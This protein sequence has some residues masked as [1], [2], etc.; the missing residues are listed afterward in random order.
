[1]ILGQISSASSNGKHSAEK[2]YKE[3]DGH[4]GGN[5]IWKKAFAFAV[6]KAALIA[7]WINFQYHKTQQLNQSLFFWMG[8]HKTSE[9]CKIDVKN[10][11]F[12]TY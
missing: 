6:N 9:L 3:G 10:W 11:S 12:Y 8:S 5:T 1:M 2:R 4:H 7:E